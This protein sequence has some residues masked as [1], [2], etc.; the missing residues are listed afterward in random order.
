MGA[1]QKAGEVRHRQALGACWKRGSLLGKPAS[2]IVGL[3]QQLREEDH[4]FKISH[5]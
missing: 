1:T 5:S 4:S 2:Q 3:K